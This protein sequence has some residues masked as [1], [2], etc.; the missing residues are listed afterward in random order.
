MAL[1]NAHKFVPNLLH[2]QTLAQTQTQTE[3]DTH[4]RTHA[5]TT[6]WAISNLFFFN[7]TDSPVK[8]FSVKQ[9]K[10]SRLFGFLE[11]VETKR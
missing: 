5:H 10:G 4:T 11:S 2:M 7:L 8:N 6:Q 3:I 9:K 1:E